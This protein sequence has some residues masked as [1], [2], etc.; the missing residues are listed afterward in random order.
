MPFKGDVQLM[1]AIKLIFI[2]HNSISI[3]ADVR[4]LSTMSKDFTDT[5]IPRLS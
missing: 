3:G 5:V 1:S 2:N 4:M